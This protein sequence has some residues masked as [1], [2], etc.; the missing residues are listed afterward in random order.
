MHDCLLH[1]EAPFASHLL[2]TQEGVLDDKIPEERMLG[3]EAGFAWKKRSDA[4]VV[5]I[6]RGMSKGM[7]L[8][9]RKTV[10]FRQPIEYRVLPGYEKVIQPMIVTLTGASGVGK[11]TLVRRVIELRPGT[12]L[13]TSLTTRPARMTDLSGEYECEM[14]RERFEKHAE[15][16]LWVLPAHGNYYATPKKAVLEAFVF[17][18]SFGP[19]C[20]ILVPE[21]VSLL[22]IYLKQFENHERNIVSFYVLSPPEDELRRRLRARGDDE[23]MIQGR[24]DDCRQWDAEALKSD[25]PYVFLSNDEIGAGIENA[26]KQMCV[27]L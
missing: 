23:G 22:H 13:V 16:F 6:N 9:V 21:A 5:Y 20:M 11:S 10:E 7:Y 27:F 2:Y 1:G 14:P 8:G 26:I 15:D 4:T 24:I 25:I 12:K 3:I 18:R 17:H 19:Q